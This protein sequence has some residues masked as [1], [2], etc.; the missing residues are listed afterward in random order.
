M[1]N[2][3]APR[4]AGA[5]KHMSDDGIVAKRY[6]L[7]RRIG[8]GGMGRVWLAR[9][10]VLR[11]SVAIKEVL[12]PEGLTEAEAVELRMRTLREA[13]AAARL[14]HPNVIKIY[15]V[16]YAEDRPWIV[17]EYVD[18]RSLAQIIKEDGPMKPEAVAAVGLALLDALCSAHDAGVLH[19]DVKPGNVLISADGR[20]VLTDFGLATFDDIGNQL[21]QTGV[22]HGS[23]QFIAPERALDGTSSPEADLWSLGAT[24][25]AAVEGRAPYSRVSSFATLT[26]LATAPPDPPL[27]AG[28]LKPVLGGLLRR[29]PRSR[30]P[31]DE[32]RQR[33]QLIM[34]GDPGRRGSIPRQRKQGDSG[35]VQALRAGAY[36]PSGHATPAPSAPTSTPPAGPAPTSPGP[37]GSPANGS[38]GP[39]TPVGL[40]RR[41][42][43]AFT[44]PPWRPNEGGE[45]PGGR[46]G[47]ATAGGDVPYTGSGFDTPAADS[48]NGSHP[49]TRPGEPRVATRGLG[50][51]LAESGLAEFGPAN[52]SVLDDFRPR[53][54]GLEEAG[55]TN[56]RAA[57][58]RLRRSRI[59]ESRL[60]AARR[61]DAYRGGARS[62]TSVPA[63]RI[64]DAR[65]AD[66]R[67]AGGDYDT[68]V[69]TDRQMDL[70]WALD[71]SDADTHRRTKR[72]MGR[73][74]DWADGR[75]RTRRQIIGVVTTLVL[76]GA[77][78]F[79]V[80]HF[81]QHRKH[82]P[83]VVK[84]AVVAARWPCPTTV[85]GS[86]V[87]APS[88]KP[89]NTRFGVAPGFMTYVDPLG[90]QVTLPEG[91]TFETGN[92][93]RC[94]YDPNAARVLGIYRWVPTDTKP[95]VALAKQ[96]AGLRDDGDFPDFQQVV[97]APYTASGEAQLEFTYQGPTALMHM[98]MHDYLAPDG[99][100]YTM[101]WVGPNADW[102]SDFYNLIEVSF[103]R[104]NPSASPAPR[105]SS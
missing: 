58:S 25:Y 54:N 44:D 29:N 101:S 99:T 61:G 28:A 5:W 88:S 84:P 63:G 73:R 102:G 95:D 32:V 18:S 8:S 98:V 74:G 83:G 80:Q 55:P 33:L 36:A 68:D 49:E 34:G 105:T 67:L 11:R 51:R 15:D 82:S 30:M 85:I 62:E 71:P 3:H 72:D 69:D 26:A 1:R 103:V 64:D 104:V 35:D 17:M 38:P 31:A 42:A 94:F 16:M 46:I 2:F 50:E 70:A 96:V 90:F 7:G 22:V 97:T 91:T 53:D 65:F 78:G 10:E 76:V 79:A 40:P 24:L 92:D 81:T 93:V 86:P 100:A 27:H 19:R 89:I 12:L 48:S 4:S 6:R 45:A 60:A 77:G 87:P 21:T 41:N 23:P 37:T 59:G 14:S 66:A 52:E 9:D 20:V 56:G 13:R 57:E 47:R 43:R 39:I 75:Q